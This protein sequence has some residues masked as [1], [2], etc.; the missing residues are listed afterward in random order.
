MERSE[1]WNVLAQIKTL[2][3]S[4][5]RSKASYVFATICA[6]FSIAGHFTSTIFGSDAQ[7]LS[8]FTAYMGLV[9]PNNIICVLKCE[10]SN[11]LEAFVSIIPCKSS[12]IVGLPINVH[13]SK[14]L[15]KG[16]NERA[17]V[18]RKV[19][20]ALFL[21]TANFSLLENV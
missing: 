9:S 11:N 8:M 1:S 5:N 20:I 12:P 17:I 16:T 19:L 10:Y 4:E 21:Y 7:S 14:L 2:W 3:H 6:C 18:N 15:L 13:L